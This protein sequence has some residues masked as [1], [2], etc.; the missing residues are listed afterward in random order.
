VFILQGTGEEESISRKRTLLLDDV[1][2]EIILC[3]RRV[4]RLRASPRDCG[5]VRLPD[6]SVTGSTKVPLQ[7][8]KGSIEMERK[9]SDR[10]K[11]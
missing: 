8:A 10:E 4:T 3:V 5:T 6:P 11:I 7:E 2:P 9:K 1:Y